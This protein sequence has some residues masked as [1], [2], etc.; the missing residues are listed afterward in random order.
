MTMKPSLT[1]PTPP[2]QSK[3]LVKRGMTIEQNEYN[4]CFFATLHSF[5]IL[6]STFHSLRKFIDE[7]TFGV[8]SYDI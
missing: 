2:P 8:L 4:E 1:P 5:R 6:Q 3:C 7:T